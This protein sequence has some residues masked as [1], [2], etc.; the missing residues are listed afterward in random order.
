MFKA[1]AYQNETYIDSPTKEISAFSRAFGT[2]KSYFE[3]LNEPANSKYL[4]RFRY[5]VLGVSLFEHPEALV[6]G[7][8]F[9]CRCL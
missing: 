1:A 6:D 8:F 3:W 4:E 7:L 9:C 5:L 2:N